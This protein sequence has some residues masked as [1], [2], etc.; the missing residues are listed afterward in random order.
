MDAIRDLIDR[1][2]RAARQDTPVAGLRLYRAEAPSP[3]V[4]TLYR[5]TLC[6]VAQ[7]RKQVVLGDSLY[8]FDPSKYLIVTVDLP[9]TGCIVE[10]SEARPYLGLSLD[11][12][13]GRVAELLLDNAAPPPNSRGAIAVTP[14]GCDL[15]D[16]MTRLLR[17][18][19]RPEDVPVLAPLIERE[20]HYR[21]LQGEQGAL[22]RQA[23]TAGS[24]LSRVGQAADWIRRHYAE[25]VSVEA[26]AELA[27]MSVTSFHRHFRAITTMTPLQYR[28]R[29]RLQEA[30]RLMIVD[31][32]NAGA[33]GFDVGYESQSQFNREYRRMFGV[34][35]AT[36]AARLRRAEAVPQHAP[37]V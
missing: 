12:D 7:G 14:L 10:A 36:D 3:Q 20:V 17:L 6:L 18:L 8:E 35:P 5:P 22:L 13:P 16:P 30:R 37:A 23:A 28:T 19:D 4:S 27:G 1:H 33:I 11:L 31:G 24:H 9:V 34:P 21:L 29:I 25:P 15:L 2:C 26:L 32:Q